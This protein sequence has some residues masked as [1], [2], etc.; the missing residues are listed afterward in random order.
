MCLSETV[1]P[2]WVVFDANLSSFGKSIIGK[3]SE[4]GA[5]AARKVA[6]IS[7]ITGQ[8]RIE[9]VHFMEGRCVF[10]TVELLQKIWK[11]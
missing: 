5:A 11:N 8:V 9:S 6:L 3:M 10:M 4:Q 1:E 2:C 7:G